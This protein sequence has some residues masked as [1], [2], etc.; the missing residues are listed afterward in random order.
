M[1]MVFFFLMIRPPPRSTLTDT[2][3]PYT[4]LFRS[5][6][7]RRD[8]HADDRG[9]GRLHLVP[10]ADR[11]RG[12]RLWRGR[13]SSCRHALLPRGGALYPQGLSTPG[14]SPR[15]APP[16]VFGG[17]VPGLRFAFLEVGERLLVRK[18]VVLGKGWPVR[19]DL[20]GG[21]VI[22]KKKKKQ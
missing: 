8:R 9:H 16:G 14:R 17:S 5:C 19:V 20:G 4:T 10:D 21:C 12:R 3:F 18:R 7:P 6:A 11:P 15:P 13:D 2:L 1:F 22:K